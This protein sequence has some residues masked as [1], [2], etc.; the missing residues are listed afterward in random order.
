MKTGRIV[1]AVVLAVVVGVAAVG[2]GARAVAAT[3]P[4]AHRE[5]LPNGIVLLVAERPAVPIVAVRAFTRAGAVLEPAELPLHPQVAARGLL[6]ES[7][8]LM[9][10]LFPALLDGQG[11]APRP[12]VQELDCAAALAAWEA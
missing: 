9:Q 5:V 10:A 11:P 4:L 8:G 1:V 12:E 2:P 3:G 6:V 7:G